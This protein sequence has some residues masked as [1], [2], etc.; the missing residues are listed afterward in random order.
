MQLLDSM[1]D[2]KEHGCLLQLRNVK[3]MIEELLIEER[4][5]IEDAFLHG[6]KDGLLN[7]HQKPDTFFNSTY[8]Q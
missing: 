3:N 7:I 2:H 6:K 8:R 5:Q 1:N 4:K